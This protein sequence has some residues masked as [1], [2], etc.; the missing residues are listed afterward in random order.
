MGTN[1]ASSH[2]Y[3]Q[4]TSI[5][6]VKNY[7][8]PLVILHSHG[9]S[10][11]LIGKPSINGSFS[12]AMLVYQRVSHKEPLSSHYWINPLLP[13]INIQKI[14][15]LPSGKRLH[16]YERLYGKSPCSMGKPSINRH[17]QVRKFA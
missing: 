4:E 8:Y 15:L 17:L 7:S 2:F 5:G 11:F 1:D 13:P 14:P 3:T 16:N 10:P 6:D 12:I 9:K